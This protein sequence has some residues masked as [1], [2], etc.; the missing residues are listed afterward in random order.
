MMDEPISAAFEASALISGDGRPETAAR[1]IDETL[2]RSLHYQIGAAA[3]GAPH[4]SRAHDRTTWLRAE[5]A[6]GVIPLLSTAE[7]E[8]PIFCTR[9]MSPVLFASSTFVH[10][11]AHARAHES[12][13][14]RAA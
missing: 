8:P 1:A 6:A 9:C 4:I 13:E 7:G 2:A 10:G 3:D 14:R 12:S 5:A 11:G